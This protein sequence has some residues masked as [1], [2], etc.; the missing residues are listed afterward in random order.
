MVSI[1]WIYELTGTIVLASAPDFNPRM[2]SPEGFS[3]ANTNISWS[4]DG[5]HILFVGPISNNETVGEAVDDVGD[6]WI[7]E[8]SQ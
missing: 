8:Q 7:I 2:I 1:H 3:F 5:G 6:L 4:P